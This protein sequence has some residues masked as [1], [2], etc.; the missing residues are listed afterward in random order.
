MPL[1]IIE[2]TKCLVNSVGNRAGGAPPFGPMI[3]QNMEW[4]TCPPPLLRIARGTSS[5]SALRFRIN[6]SGLFFSKPGC[7]ATAAFKLVHVSGVV[8]VMV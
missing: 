7:F 4:F 3:C 8:L 2:A 1:E 6:S 5:G